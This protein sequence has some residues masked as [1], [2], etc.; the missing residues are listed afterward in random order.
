R[1]TVPLT[2]APHQAVFVVFRKAAKSNGGVSELTRDGQPVLQWAS[3]WVANPQEIVDSNLN[4]SFWIKP[5][6]TINLPVPRL[7]GIEL[8][9]QSW[10]LSP[11][12]GTF[13]R[14]EGF[15]GTGVS[16]GTNGV[17]VSQHWSDN[18]PAVLVWRAPAPITD[19]THVLVSYRDGVPHLFVNGVEVATGL[20]SGQRIVEGRPGLAGEDTAEST[21]A[22][23]VRGVKT[24]YGVLSAA[25]IAALAKDESESIPVAPLEAQVVRTAAGGLNLQANEGG[26]YAL[27]LKNGR[28]MNVTVPA[29]PATFNLSTP[30]DITFSGAAAPAPVRW[31]ELKSWS[32]SSDETTKYF[33]G[34]ATYTTSFDLPADYKPA[35][36]LCTL[37][38][39]SVRIVA[40][41]TVNGQE[42]GTALRSPYTLEIGRFLKPGRNTLSVLV[43]NTWANR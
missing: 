37:D 27:T 4:Q 32:E 12:Q 35:S 2:L 28:S 31:N 6:R 33:S 18:A 1:T 13:A 10:A 21:F 17:V 30:W 11:P 22:A 7:G 14:G 24:S 9:N 19:W 39:G 38:L 5:A 41:A 3:N 15:A 42:A 16:V 26:V 36:S 25:E 20:K 29:P 23:N 8:R 40:R 34:N 43:T